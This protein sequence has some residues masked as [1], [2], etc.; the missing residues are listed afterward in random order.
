MDPAEIRFIWEAE[1]SNGMLLKEPRHEMCSG[2]LQSQIVVVPKGICSC[3][4]NKNEAE[5]WHRCT[6]IYLFISSNC[7]LKLTSFYFDWEVQKSPWWQVRRIVITTFLQKLR[8]P[9]LK[10]KA[11]R[12]FYYRWVVTSGFK[13][14]WRESNSPCNSLIGYLLKWCCC[15]LVWPKSL[16]QDPSFISWNQPP[17]M[18]YIVSVEIYR[19]KTTYSLGQCFRSGTKL[20]PDLIG[21]MDLDPV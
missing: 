8:D 9:N 15:S 16:W 10:W 6:R 1:G 5:L 12:V 19:E 13:V 7:D 18:S 21:S 14:V 3:F 11:G 2:I 4:L 17:P 20:D